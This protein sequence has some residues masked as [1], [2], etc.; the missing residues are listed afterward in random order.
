MYV[1]A[2]GASVCS[3]MPS[4]LLRR[5]RQRM[6]RRPFVG[7]ALLPLAAACASGAGTARVASASEAASASS[8]P[9]AFPRAVEDFQQQNGE[10]YDDPGAGVRVGYISPRGLR[11]DAFLY[12]IPGRA[13]DTSLSRSRAAARREAMR[14][15]EVVR[16]FG[17]RGEYA[18]VKLAKP[19]TFTATGPTGRLIAGSYVAG[20]LRKDGVPM[21]SDIYVFV[22]GR[23]Y[24]KIRATNRKDGPAAGA[25]DAIRTF[26]VGL[27]VAFAEAATK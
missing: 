15:A 12:P 5:L 25:H 11:A 22:I 4:L 2:W 27:A 23:Q 13:V 6:C 24:L 14:S 18:Q 20:S 26:A 7:L 19:D 8:S 10:R 16:I 17:R 21:L 3:R 1:V 9:L